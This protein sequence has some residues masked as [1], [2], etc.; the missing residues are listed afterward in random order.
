MTTVRHKAKFHLIS[1]QQHEE[2]LRKIQR[3]AAVGDEDY[4][5]PKARGYL[6]WI[7]VGIVG[8]CLF[9]VVMWVV[10]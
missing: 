7:A 5:P 2:H 10:T 8:F 3:Q 4:L 6:R 9:V 1:M